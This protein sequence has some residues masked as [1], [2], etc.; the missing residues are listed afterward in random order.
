M[1]SVKSLHD[2]GAELAEKHG[3]QPEFVHNVLRHYF[4]HFLPNYGVD[5]IQ[6]SRRL[7]PVKNP[8]TA[9]K[10]IIEAVASYPSTMTV[11]DV[12]ALGDAS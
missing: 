10:I 11:G 3:A 4:E 8:T 2:L 12:L 5:Q 1:C 6:I 7:N 9:Q